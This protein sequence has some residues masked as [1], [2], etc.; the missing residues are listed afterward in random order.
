MLK[1]LV[2]KFGREKMMTIEASKDQGSKT[3]SHIC[4]TRNCCNQSHILIETKEINDS[5]VHCHFFLKRSESLSKKKNFIDMYCLH[6]P[7]CGTLHL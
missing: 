4:G 2:K 5:R 7:K 1:K 3:I 6:N